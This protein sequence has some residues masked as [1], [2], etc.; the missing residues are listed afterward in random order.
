VHSELLADIVERQQGEC[1][2][3][4]AAGRKDGR[5]DGRRSPEGQW[6]DDV[7]EDYWDRKLYSRER[8]ARVLEG[9][10]QPSKA[11]QWA[12]RPDWWWFMGGGV[13]KRRAGRAMPHG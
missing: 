9:Q 8:E 12:K 13:S 5:K 2:M 3:L 10:L 11:K 7:Q 6:Q 1:E 4:K